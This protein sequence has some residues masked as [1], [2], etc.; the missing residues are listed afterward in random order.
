MAETDKVVNVT[1]ESVADVQGRNGP[2]IQLELEVPWSKWPSK[3]WVNTGVFARPKVG[4][5]HQVRFTRG[6]LKED[7][8]PDMDWNYRWY[9]GEWDTGESVSP[10]APAP[11]PMPSPA[12]PG[13]GGKTRQADPTRRSIERQVAFKGAIDLAAGQ[14]IDI[15]DVVYWTEI[16]ARCIEDNYEEAA[17]PAAPVAPD[18][19]DVLDSPAAEP[20]EEPLDTPVCQEH[21]VAFEWRTSTTGNS[22]WCHQKTGGGYCIYDGPAAVEEWTL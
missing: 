15:Q 7:A 16:F 1:V 17:T 5:Q 2:Q 20:K 10:P 21:A 9:I 3:F 14:I 12:V 8:D 19:P 6:A 22:R 13:G 11:T 4:E 18:A